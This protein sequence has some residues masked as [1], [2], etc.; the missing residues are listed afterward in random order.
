MHR[1]VSSGNIIIKPT[2]DGE[3][4]G[5]LI[6]FDHA[7]VTKEFAAV[8]RSEVTD[9][10]LQRYKAFIHDDLEMK[11][12]TLDD[13]VVIKALQVVRPRKLLEYIGEVLAI[14]QQFFNF[15][16]CGKLTPVDLHWDMMVSIACN[17]I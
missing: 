14:R 9:E 12:D 17:I 16:V 13:E 2:D 1:D 6:D 4:I 8:K 10:R 5:R 3:T 15:S 7:K 11:P